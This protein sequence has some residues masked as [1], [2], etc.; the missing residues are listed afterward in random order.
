M[1]ALARNELRLFLIVL[2]M[3]DKNSKTII[4]KPEKKVKPL[5]FVCALVY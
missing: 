5:Q 3:T 1:R 2:L 4:K